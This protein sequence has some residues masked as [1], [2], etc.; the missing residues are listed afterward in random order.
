MGNH[1]LNAIAITILCAT[2]LFSAGIPAEVSTT[3]NDAVAADRVFELVHNQ[4]GSFDLHAGQVAVRE[5]LEKI[6][7]T[8]GVKVVAYK[9]NNKSSVSIN[10]RGKALPQ[11]LETVVGDK[12]LMLFG[13]GRRGAGQAVATSRLSEQ[14]RGDYGDFA[15]KVAVEN[16]IARL[17]FTPNDT[18]QGSLDHYIKL[19][20]YVLDTLAERQPKKEIQAQISFTRYLTAEQLAAFIKKYP[21][22]PVTLNFGWQEQGGGYD[23]KKG[24]SIH[25]ALS[26]AARN[27]ERF[28]RVL[29]TEAQKQY[30][31]KK[32]R[33]PHK[34][35]A[36]A[37][38]DYLSQADALKD[39]YRRRGLLFYGVRTAASVEI[40]KS[41]KD[42][43]KNVR[44]IDPLWGGAVEEQLAT[45][46]RIKKIAIPIIPAKE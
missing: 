29:R 6:W 42:Q 25:Q 41:V 40:L 33:G 9:E 31:Q 37:A 30:R 23:I 11:L 26:N 28:I 32:N 44:L 34:E 45:A 38:A 7:Q 5:V 20:H 17:F 21:I 19:R 35:S 22:R 15:G 10:I 8:T 39:V 4:D 36:N 43:E 12:Y 27:H 24:E 13:E 16:K 14:T 1:I 2:V 3:A 18:H 46:Y